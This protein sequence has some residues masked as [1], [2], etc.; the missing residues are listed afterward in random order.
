MTYI[1][2]FENLRNQLRSLET[3]GTN[4][5]ILPCLIYN[6]VYILILYILNLNIVYIL[7]LYVSQVD[8]NMARF[9]QIGIIGDKIW[10]LKLLFIM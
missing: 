6:I 5:V 2:H 8:C 3:W 10:H 4:N 1:A 9:H 7:N